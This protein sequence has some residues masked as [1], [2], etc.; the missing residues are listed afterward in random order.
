MKDFFAVCA[1]PEKS[2]SPTLKFNVSVPGL[3]MVGMLLHISWRMS[4]SPFFFLT[5][6]FAP[7]KKPK[8]I[9]Y[10][11]HIPT[12]KSAK[13]TSQWPSMR[14]VYT[15]GCMWV[16]QH[17]TDS[18]SWFFLQ[19]MLMH[20]CNVTILIHKLYNIDVINQVMPT[21]RWEVRCLYLGYINNAGLVILRNW[22]DGAGFFKSS[23]W[24]TQCCQ[25]FDKLIKVRINDIARSCWC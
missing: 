4:S 5:V 9:R 15:R 3:G 20:L 11:Q 12:F 23:N 2:S 13:W 19:E 14:C 17:T 10:K 25:L 1:N 6:H 8:V 7:H 18:K 21:L 22:Q 16:S 24:K